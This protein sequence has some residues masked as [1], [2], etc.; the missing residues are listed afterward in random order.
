MGLRGLEFRWAP[1]VKEV[2]TLDL[3]S[4]AYE[5]KSHQWQGQYVA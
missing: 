2:N 5:F 4:G 3:K 1:V